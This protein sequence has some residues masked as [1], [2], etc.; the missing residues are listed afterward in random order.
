[1]KYLVFLLGGVCLGL[2]LVTSCQNQSSHFTLATG[3]KSSRHYQI[4]LSLAEMINQKSRYRW[5]LDTTGEGSINNCH[6]LLAKKAQFA[7]AQNDV[8]LTEAKGELRT[9]LPLY[10]QIFLIVYKDSIQANSLQA[11]IEGRKIAVGPKTGGTAPFARK[12]FQLMGIDSSKYEFVYSHY[13]E[14]TISDTIPISISVTGVD[15][16]RIKEMLMHKHGKIWS[17]DSIETFGKGSLVE[18]FCLQY[19]LARPFVLPKNT[20]QNHP[21]HPI[22]TIAMDNLLLAHKS[23]PATVIYD[24]LN[25]IF[26]NEEILSSKDILF[27]NIAED[28]DRKSLQFPMH[29][30]LKNYL[31]RN[32]PSFIERYADILALMI[33][34]LTIGMGTFSTFLQWN[35]KRRKE[36]IDK[37]YLKVIQLENEAK[38]KTQPE[39]LNVVLEALDL[40]RQKAFQQLTDEKL[41]AD[42][43]FRIFVALIQDVIS[44]VRKRLKN[45]EKSQEDYD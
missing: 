2:M 14:N 42:D 29:E 13:Q 1:M 19:P 30:G 35:K 22:L 10:P 21:Q 40:L 4:G 28:F 17:L 25:T 31:N 41:Q 12:F 15:N 36:R 11:L 5:H 6:E 43:S 16:A 18:G 3:S 26:E 24:L 23:V 9:V 27:H 8:P 34:A 32:K 37:Y 20:Y 7:L 39:D 44:L 45:I 33:T 38:S